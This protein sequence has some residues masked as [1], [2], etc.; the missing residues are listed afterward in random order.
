MLLP[1]GEGVVARYISQ[2]AG[3]VERED[4]DVSA[5]TELKAVDAAI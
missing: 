1:G 4:A 3:V 2:M 5:A